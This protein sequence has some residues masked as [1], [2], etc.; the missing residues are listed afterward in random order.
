VIYANVASKLFEGFHL[1]PFQTDTTT[2]FD[3]DFDAYKLFGINEAPQLYTMS[4]NDK[5]S[6]NVLPCT[7]EE[8]AIPLCLKVGAESNYEI[9]VSENTLWETVD[10]SLKD[11]ETQITYDLTTS[12]QLTINQST[13]NSPDRFLLLIN[14]ATGIEE[15]KK[16]DG[17][18]IYSYGN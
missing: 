12:T 10:V 4:G 18:E 14:G 9:S 7:S 1:H 15:D 5:L 6:I 3:H 16:D 13:D 17:I 11:L 8:I 2:G